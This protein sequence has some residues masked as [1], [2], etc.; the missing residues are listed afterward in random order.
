MSEEP[1]APSDNERPAG[2]DNPL[3][4]KLGIRAHASG[5]IVSPPQDAD[6][7][8]LPLPDGF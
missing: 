8:L 5:L 6:N 3:H 7:P 4:K 1:T 2:N